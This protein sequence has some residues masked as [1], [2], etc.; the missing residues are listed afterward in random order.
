M[1]AVGGFDRG[2]ELAAACERLTPD[3]VP[4][5]AAVVV[6]RDGAE[7]PCAAGVAD[8]ETGRPTT[9]DSAHLWFSMTKIVTA[10]AAMQ[11]VDRGSLDLDDPVS[12]WLPEFPQ[13]RSGWPPVLVRHL[14]SHSSGLTNPIPV[15]WVHPAGERPRD[16]R[17]FTLSLLRR[18]RKL[19]SP[20]GS[21]AVYSNLGY[22]ALGEVIAAASGQTYT[23]YVR[24]N[25]LTPLGMDRSGFTYDDVGDD[26]ATGHQRRFH[27]MTP[28]FRVLLPLG[29]MG[30][31]RGRFVSFNRFCVDGPAY[32]GLIG[33][34][35]DAA[36][37]VAAH[38]NGGELRG[39]RLL[40]PESVDA[41]QT[42]QARGP[43]M[44][45]G[46]GWYRRGRSRS[47]ADF[48]EHLGGGGGFRTLL[49]IYPRRGLGVVAM[50]NASTYDHQ[51]IAAAAVAESA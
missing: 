44:D 48:V 46:F 24:A 36:G 18:H 19:R 37:F 39:V 22:L 28:L 41:M 17:E 3:S 50:G 33:P 16:A 13:P 29:I 32:G 43:R 11:L 14:L 6:R 40:S 27:P 38:L 26:V 25:V 49:R 30:A 35:R 31:N 12:G 2:D 5:I 9:P 15:R 4:G 42:I 21:K 45:V 23:E 34:V 7:Q 10:T 1:D 51:A 8:L 47:G 20:A